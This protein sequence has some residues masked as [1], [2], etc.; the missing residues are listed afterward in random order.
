MIL[1]R[2]EFMLMNNPVRAWIQKRF[3]GPRFE[4]M[5][6]TLGG[7]HALEIGFIREVCTYVA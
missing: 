2:L 7:G 1:N 3:E 6:G 4:R 5:G